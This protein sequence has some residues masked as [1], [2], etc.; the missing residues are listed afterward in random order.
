MSRWRELGYI[1]DSAE[2]RREEEV[3]QTGGV[4]EP[5]W[6]PPLSLEGEE[7]DTQAEGAALLGN[8]LH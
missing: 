6:G 2:G 5:E 3:G 4:Q 1:A 7:I 8:A